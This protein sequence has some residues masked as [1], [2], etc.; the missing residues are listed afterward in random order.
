LFHWEQRIG[1]YLSA[2]FL[3][4][5]LVWRDIFLP[6]NCRSL[7]CDILACDESKRARGNFE[8][9]RDILTR[10]SPDLLHFPVNPLP[11][12]SALARIRNRL[13]RFLRTRT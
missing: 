8:L 12:P 7:I 6:Y 13:R 2:G 11:R 4:F 5:E 3:E 9:Y 1:S 10:L